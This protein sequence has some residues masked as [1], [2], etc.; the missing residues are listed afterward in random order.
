MARC[1]VLGAAAVSAALGL[2]M[3]AIDGYEVTVEK[4]IADDALAGIGAI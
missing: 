4:T 1:L 3:A 2:S